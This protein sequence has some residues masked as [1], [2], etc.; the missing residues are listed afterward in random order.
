MWWEIQGE[1]RKRQVRELVASGQLEIVNGGFA[2]TDEACPTYD[3]MITNYIQGAKF[4]KEAFGEEQAAK[5]K[6]GWQLDPFGHSNTL[7]KIVAEMGYEAL[8]FA[9]IKQSDK[10]L[11]AKNQSLE[12]LWDV[13]P[14]APPLFTH[15]FKNHYSSPKEY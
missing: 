13:S 8:F 15:I 11:M 14:Y 12:F 3:A 10:E 5:L 4:V 1:K 6:I 2:S 7:A 9:R